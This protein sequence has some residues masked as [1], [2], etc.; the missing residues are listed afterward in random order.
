MPLMSESLHPGERALSFAFS[1]IQYIF[2]S[3][4][5]LTID[6]LNFL[7][8]NCNYVPF[9]HHPW[10]LPTRE[11]PQSLVITI[12]YA[13]FEIAFVRFHTSEIMICLC[14]WFISLNIVSST[15][16]HIVADDGISFVFTT[17]RIP[18]W[19]CTHAH[20]QSFFFILL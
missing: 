1:G 11:P 6:P 9:D 5:G 10:P 18:L 19:A 8:S 20:T 17:C 3:Y 4:C 16:L 12:L 15:S 14:A 7:L 2:I 13:F